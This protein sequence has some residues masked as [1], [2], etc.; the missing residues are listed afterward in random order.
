MV[1]TWRQCDIRV[2]KVDRNLVSNAEL[3]AL[4]N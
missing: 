4:E 3:T 2:E 1:L